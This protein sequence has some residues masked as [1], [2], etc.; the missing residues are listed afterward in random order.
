MLLTLQK[1]GARLPVT[2]GCGR[3]DA[4]QVGSESVPI[5]ISSITVASSPHFC[6]F[7]LILPQR[8]I[9]SLTV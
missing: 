7:L 1:R 5:K 4:A 2:F 8:H 3:P 9:S 6:D